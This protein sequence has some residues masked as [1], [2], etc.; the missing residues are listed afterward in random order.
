MESYERNEL[1]NRCG[2]T[3]GRGVGLLVHNDKVLVTA[4]AK[5]EAFAK[6]YE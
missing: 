6:V 5:A 1:A 2:A 4:R 3:K